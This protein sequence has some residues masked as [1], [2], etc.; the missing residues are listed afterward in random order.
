V[1]DIRGTSLGPFTIVA[2]THV[3]LDIPKD[4]ALTVR[5][6]WCSLCPGDFRIRHYAPTIPPF[7]LARFTYHVNPQEGVIFAFC[8]LSVFWVWRASSG[9]R[10]PGNTTTKP[11]PPDPQA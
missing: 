10:W 3:K 1:S 5:I 4:S 9:Q 2:V 6:C 7:G 8:H 11:T